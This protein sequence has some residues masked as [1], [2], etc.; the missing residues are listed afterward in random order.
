MAL[1]HL[2]P[3]EHFRVSYPCGIGQPHRGRLGDLAHHDRF[4]NAM[5]RL[6]LPLMLP[7]GIDGEQTLE[8][9]P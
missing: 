9:Y 2:S 7:C 6:F 5:P 8:A 3:F 4:I 1:F